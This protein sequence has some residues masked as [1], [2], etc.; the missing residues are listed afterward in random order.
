VLLR[1]AVPLWFKKSSVEL[2]KVQECDA[3]GD[4]IIIK[5]QVHKIYTKNVS[6]AFFTFYDR[7]FF[8][9]E[10]ITVINLPQQPE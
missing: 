5:S 4:A 9:K 6:P 8:F 1:A 10:N 3:R 2:L 7:I